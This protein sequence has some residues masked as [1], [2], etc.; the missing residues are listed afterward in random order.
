MDWSAVRKVDP[1]FGQTARPEMRTRHRPARKGR[2]LHN[3]GACGGQQYENA[4]SRSGERREDRQPRV[5]LFD[6]YQGQVSAE[7]C[8]HH[9][10]GRS[11]ERLY[12]KT[13][14]QD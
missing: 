6:Q 13:T 1:V 8:S 11:I 2:V 7:G 10:T 4:G 14:V 5:K 9:R 12:K 3:S